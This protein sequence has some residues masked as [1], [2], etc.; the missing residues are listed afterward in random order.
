LTTRIH[1]LHSVLTA[2]PL[3]GLRSIFQFIWSRNPVII[4]NKC[5][6][7]ESR[8]YSLGYSL[9]CAYLGLYH[10][11]RRLWWFQWIRWICWH[12]EYIQNWVDKFWHNRDII[13]CVL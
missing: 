10:H 12:H 5:D 9:A 2:A 11:G 13:Q 8:R 6:I 1:Y 7:V 4:D 3:I